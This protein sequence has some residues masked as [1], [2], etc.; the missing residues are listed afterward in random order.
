MNLPGEFA[1]SGDLSIVQYIGLAGGPTKDGSVDRVVVYST[2]GRARG[3]GRDARVNRG[4]VIVVKKSAYKLFGDFVGG[5]IRLGTVVISIIV[6]SN[7]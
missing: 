5:V 1:Y 6:L 3:V 2:D 7:Q 4:D